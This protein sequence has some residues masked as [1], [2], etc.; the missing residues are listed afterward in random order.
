LIL[1]VDDLVR[2]L[3]AGGQNS[4][5]EQSIH[6]EADGSIT[7]GAD[8]RRAEAAWYQG[9]AAIARYGTGLIVDEVFLG[10]RASQDRLAEA[11]SD[12][13]C[14]GSVCAAIRKS[15]PRARASASTG[16]QAWRD[17]KQSEST[18]GSSMT[19]S[20]TRRTRAPRS[21]PAF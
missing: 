17:S 3:P 21:A 14:S 18:K 6:F 9:L 2:A 15:R 19:W 11:L 7:V 16:S 12:L 5:D 4:G 8:F 13:T 10:G 1:G 20:W